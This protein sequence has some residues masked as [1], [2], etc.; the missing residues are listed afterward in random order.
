MSVEQQAPSRAEVRAAVGPATSE[1]VFLALRR[2]RVP[3][4]VLLTL[5]SISVLGLTLIP[6][7]NPDG[8]TWRMGFFDAFYFMSYTATT[9]GYGELPQS[10]NG[11]Q[12][13]WVTL[14][15]YLSVI[16]WAYAIGALLSLLQSRPFRQ[17]I[18]VQRFRRAVRTLREPFWLMAG[19]GHTGELLGTWLDGLGKRFV[20]VDVREEAVDAL[21]LGSYTADVPAI[22]AD[23]STPDALVQAGLLH[24][25]CVGVLA[26]TDDDEVNLSVV[27]AASVMRPELQVIARTSTPTIKARMEVFGEPIV[28]DPFDRFGDHFAVSLHAPAIEQLVDWLTRAPEAPLPERHEDI[29]SGAW[30]LYGYGRFGREVTRDLRREG[31]EVRVIDIGTGLA[32]EPDGTEGVIVGDATRREILDEADIEHAVGFIAGTD[33]DVT[34]LSL[35]RAA[36]RANPSLYIVARQNRPENAELF[37][38]MSIDLLLVP[39][40]V[41]AQEALA[42]IGAP[43]LW[44]FLEHASHQGQQWAS[45]LVD[46]L[47][48]RCGRGS[49]ELWQFA[50]TAEDAPAVV[51]VMARHPILL[52]DLLRDPLDRDQVVEVV[53]L[54][55]DGA[56]GQVLAPP[57]D[58]LLAPG[59]RLLLAGRASGRRSMESTLLVDSSAAYCLSDEPA[60][61]GWLWRRLTREDARRS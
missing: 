20:V 32:D 14:S 12:R 30:V 16:G 22:V 28:I 15:I 45:D 4:I 13:M 48:D 21:D 56:D 57:D 36:R 1:A 47:V 34:N 53:C 7:T 42:H 8:T 11:E 39:T 38:A 6:G 10:F 2:M 17:A 27:M 44:Q 31:V 52:G 55:V 9:I 59:D 49:P 29:G 25:S 33:N 51:R 3:L 43:M 54:M 40:T 61:T 35:V 5:F 24:P 58:H 26:L 18:A 46:R 50:M 41:V 60:A 23:A 19:H 37:E